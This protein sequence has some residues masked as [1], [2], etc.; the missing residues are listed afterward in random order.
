MIYKISKDNSFTKILGKDFVNTN[1]N[2][3]FIRGKI[4]AQ[5]FLRE[6]NFF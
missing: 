3:G 5:I 6:K 2:K 1:R 4:C